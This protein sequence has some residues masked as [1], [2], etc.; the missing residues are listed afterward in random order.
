MAEQ[1]KFT[2]N[3][4]K[5]YDADERLAIGLEVIDHIL[6]RTAQGKDKN[7]KDFPGYSDSYID[8]L[9]FSLAGKSPGKVNLNLSGE[10]LGSIEV[11]DIGTDGQITIGIPAD[12]SLNNAKAEGN[13]KGTYGQKKSTGKKRDFLG[14]TR[15]DLK[16]ITS[17]FK[18]NNK[19]EREKTA[20][21]VAELLTATQLASGVIDQL[22]PGRQGGDNGQ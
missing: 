12:D 5:K 20:N 11:L 22:D 14:I 18:I 17:Q 9:D 13:I 2:I 15:S 1:Q 10:M 7:N 8:S 4:S 6:K 16:D 3:V 19:E 21:R